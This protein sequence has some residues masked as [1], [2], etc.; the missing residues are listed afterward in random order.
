MHI[1]CDAR[2]NETHI[3]ERGLDIE[4]AVDFDFGTAIIA[5]DTRRAYPEVRYVRWDF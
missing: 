2:K 3:R 4:Q 5:Q 1:E